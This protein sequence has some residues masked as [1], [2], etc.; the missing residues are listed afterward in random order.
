MFVGGGISGTTFSPSIA[1]AGSHTI[2][3]IYSDGNGCSNAYCETTDISTSKSEILINESA[4]NVYPNPNAGTFNVSF[5]LNKSEKVNIKVVN[6]LGEIIYTQSNRKAKGSYNN[7][8]NLNSQPDG[9]YYIDVEV[10]ERYYS[11]I[12]SLM[13]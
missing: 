7:T 5:S 8:I 4:I 9:I 3:Y 6:N 10:G 11:E 1:G 12:I 13:K 2:V